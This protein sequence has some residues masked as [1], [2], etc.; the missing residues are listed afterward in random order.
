[1]LGFDAVGRFA[2]GQVPA[3]LS[4]SMSVDVAAFTLAGQDIAYSINWPIDAAAYSV[5]FNDLTFGV[6]MPVDAASYTVTFNAINL[7]TSTR[8]ALYQRGQG[9]WKGSL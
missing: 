6:N 7:V 5:T 1:M 9:Y 8:R 3:S 4:F 2:I